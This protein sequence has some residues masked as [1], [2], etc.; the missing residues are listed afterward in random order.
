MRFF[1]SRP[2]RLGALVSAASLLVMAAAVPSSSAPDRGP[3]ARTSRVSSGGL[4]LDK[5]NPGYECG[6]AGVWVLQCNG[7]TVKFTDVSPSDHH[8]YVVTSSPHLRLTKRSVYVRPPSTDKHDWNYRQ[9]EAIIFTTARLKH[10]TTYRIRVKEYAGKRLLGTSGAK[11]FTYLLAGHPVFAWNDSVTLDGEEVL[12]AGETHHITFAG[13]WESRLSYHTS[14]AVSPDNSGNYV[15][16]LE[17]LVDPYTGEGSNT[18]APITTF[19]VP[20]DAAG[21]YIYW[22]LAGERGKKQS[23]GYRFG[24][25]RVVD[26]AD[27]P[28]AQDDAWVDSF[29]ESTASPAAGTT[30]SLT[31]PTYS[32]E[33]QGHTWTA[34]Y[35]WWLASA[36]RSRQI[37]TTTEPTVELPAGA[38]GQK[39]GVAVTLS[40]PGFRD[41]S[42]VI[43]LGGVS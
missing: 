38:S 11:D 27:V 19:T 30:Y 9:G 31:A 5:L 35:H 14:I 15:D 34:T 16:G 8:R 12:V 41:R 23:W 32:A 42:S 10:A 3:T 17:W 36:D 28:P 21:K 1:N 22:S 40:T 2:V 37:A 25:L 6:G 26:P 24:P 13:P 18:A 39:L 7:I 29:G 43:Y 4:S 20:Q 33:G